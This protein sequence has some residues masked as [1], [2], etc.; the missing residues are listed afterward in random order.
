MLNVELVEPVYGLACSRHLFD[1]KNES[2]FQDGTLSKSE[3]WYVTTSVRSLI[4]TNQQTSSTI[5]MTESQ[6][7]DGTL[8]KSEDWYITTSVRSLIHTNQQTS[9]TIRMTRHH[10]FTSFAALQDLFVLIAILLNIRSA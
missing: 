8:S 3:D 6:F 1:A 9:S 5:R 7:Q 2:Q 10:E 4:H